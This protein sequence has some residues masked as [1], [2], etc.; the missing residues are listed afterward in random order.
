M[1]LVEV[2][3]AV[4]IMMV[5]L[6]GMLQAMN[7]ALAHD[8]RNK[9]RDEAIAIGEDQMTQ[10]RLLPFDNIT[11]TVPDAKVSVNIRGVEREYTVHREMTPLSGSAKKLAVWVVW[12]FKNVSAWHRIYTVVHK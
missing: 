12:T 9:L 10:F 2:L 4:V 7:V 6:L 8:L 1:T 11:T 3:A 5:G